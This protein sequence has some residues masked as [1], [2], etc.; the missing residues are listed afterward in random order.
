MKS[1]RG[2]TLKSSLLTVWDVLFPEHPAAEEAIKAWLISFA[3]DPALMR[4]T[5]PPPKH[6]PPPIEGLGVAVDI[7]AFIVR[8]NFPESHLVTRDIFG[9]KGAGYME[10]WASQSPLRRH[11]S[12]PNSEVDLR[13][14]I[15]LLTYVVFSVGVIIRNAVHQALANENLIASGVRASDPMGAHSDVRAELFDALA[16]VN[17]PVNEIIFAHGS[18]PMLLARLRKSPRGSVRDDVIRIC[19]DYKTK[20]RVLPGR[21]RVYEMVQAKKMRTT[22]RECAAILKSLG[23]GDKRGRKSP[24]DNGPG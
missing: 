2:L 13:E 3:L 15:D 11:L 17:W 9:I 5:K 18:A 14:T 12:H 1:H 22:R 24:R 20:H 6:M 7:E 4:D 21:D 10:A 8:F 19:E 23:S 16:S